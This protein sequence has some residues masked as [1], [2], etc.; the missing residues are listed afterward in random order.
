MFGLRGIGG[1]GKTT[2]AV[3]VAHSDKVRQ[4][5]GADNICWIPVGQAATGM[6]VL[7]EFARKVCRHWCVDVV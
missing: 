6:D 1:V 2:T 5:F 7:E 4:T 3:A